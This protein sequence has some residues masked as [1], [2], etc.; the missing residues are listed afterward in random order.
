MMKNRKCELFP[1]TSRLCSL[2]IPG[3]PA[4]AETSLQLQVYSQG[5]L[6]FEL[7]AALLTS[8]QPT[9]S[10]HVLPKNM[11]REVGFPAEF[12]PAGFTAMRVSGL[13]RSSASI[14]G[15]SVRISGVVGE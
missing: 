12:F 7:P 8:E 10:I 1:S 5:P 15:T 11:V 2:S 6:S 4:C 13:A 9:R 14:K 3:P